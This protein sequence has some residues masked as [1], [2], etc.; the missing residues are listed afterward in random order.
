M[1]SAITV[2]PS[3]ARELLY[4][5][6]ETLEIPFTLTDRTGTVVASTAGRPIGQVD[7]YAIAVAGQGKTVEITEEELRAPEG[8]ASYSPAAEHTGLLPPAPGIYTP[9]RI[10]NEIVAV[11]FTR[12]DPEEVRTKATTAAAVAGVTLELASGATSSMHN[13]LG[14]DLALRALLRGS[15][16]EARRAML[17]AKVAGWDLLAPRVA[18]VIVPAGDATRLPQDGIVVIRDLLMALAPDTPCAQLGA[19]EWVALPALPRD[20]TQPS[21]QAVA[22]EIEKTLNEQGVPVAVGTGETHID[23][24]ILPGLRRSYREAAYVARSARGLAATG[25][26]SLKSL[27]ALAFL[28]PG[29]EMRRQLAENLLEPLRAAP[30]ILNTVRV[31]LDSNLS[32]EAAAKSSG[33]HRHTVRSHLQRARELT[34]LDVRTLADALQFKLAFLIAQPIQTVTNR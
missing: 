34:G 26:H 13:T 24:P 1:T 31:F 5:L 29:A 18:L 20:E 22:A 25:V 9:I 11:L 17:V 28:A 21:I 15:Q 14:P 6:T 3:A 23:M 27:G 16:R 12:G 4:R 10:Y 30:E 8:V 33:Q 19:D 7:A 32:L 2:V